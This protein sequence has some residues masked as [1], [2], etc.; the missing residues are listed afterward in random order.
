M[1]VKVKTLNEILTRKFNHTLK[2][3]NLIEDNDHILVGLSGGKDSLSL[4]DFL[5]ERRKNYKPSF[6]LSAMYIGVDHL[7]YS[8]DVDYLASFCKAREVPFYT[9]VIHMPEDR[10]TKRSPCFLCSWERRKAL[11]AEALKLS[12][13]KI[14]FGHH[15]DDILETLLMNQVF[16]GAYASMPPKLK[17][18]KMPITI[19]RPM[20]LLREKDLEER[21]EGEAYQKQIINCPHET[22]SSR[23]EIRQILKQMEDLN[24]N[25]ASSLWNA[26]MNVQSDYLPHKQEI[27]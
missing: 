4:L 12:C 1:A 21:A 20:C 6:T 23:P 10:D 5:V 15:L 27:N 14:A 17:L 2:T 11:F 9:R 18:E 3:Y 16:Q 26:M 19:I 25:A 22:A 7:A 24:P 8:S 13:N